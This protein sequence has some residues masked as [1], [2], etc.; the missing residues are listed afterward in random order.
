MPGELIYDGDC[1]F[2][3]RSVAHWRAITDGKI[4]AVPYQEAAERFPGLS[5]DDFRQAVHFVEDGQVWKGAAA[6]FAS[7][8][9]V[10]G[11]GWL[12]SAYQRSPLFAR[13]SEWLYQELSG[14]R[15]TA[16]WVTQLLWRG[17]LWQELP[18][19]FPNS[20]RTSVWLFTRILAVIY[21]IAFLS[22]G[23]QVKGLIGQQGILP[24]APY[25]DA[26]RNA[27]G[28]FGPAFWNVPSIFWWNSTDPMLQ[29]VCWLGVLLAI[30][31]ALGIFQRPI[32]VA[33]F[34][35]Y[36]S[37]VTA[38]QV[39][40]GYQWD[41]LLLECG[42]LAIFLTPSRP[43]VWLFQW[44][45]F[46]L[47]FESGCVKLL[48][49]DP[50][51][52]NLTALA[53][54]YQTQPLPTPLAW[55]AFQAP[56]WFHKISTAGVFLIELGAPFLIF[57]SRR[58]KHLA[59]GAFGMLQLLILLTGNYTFF[60][61]L[62]LGLCVLLLDDPSWG[63]W[64]PALRSAGRRSS[65]VVSLLLLGF[66]LALS[67]QGFSQVFSRSLPGAKLLQGFASRLAPFGVVNTYGLFASMTTMRMEIEV[68]GSM[69]GETWRT[70][71][72]R[73]KPGDIHR[74]PPWIAPF[75]PRLDWQMW[76]AALGNYQEN[77]WF[78]R[79]V[80][81][82]LTPSPAVLRLMQFD[83]F[84]GHPPRYIR[85]LAY[86]Y[87]FTNFAEQRAGGAWWHR[88]LKGVYFP[89]VSLHSQNS[90]AGPAHYFL[91]AEQRSALE[92]PINNHH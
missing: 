42:F 92:P 20:Y 48:S 31:C 36:L 52:A 15:A 68:Q 65:S 84:S 55:Y 17:T 57:G 27:A 1:P 3:R 88:D 83:P 47:M 72:F 66:I 56:L 25:L 79:F 2:C 35:L 29:A 85:A 21:G 33:L 49:H 34:V 75:Q 53:F 58:M 39:F 81:A 38:G 16:S 91:K 78:E 87:R 80:A 14:R 26:I 89:A 67:Y 37:V 18:A 41:Y 28:S 13:V 71:S 60:N 70:Y 63:R 10:R 23:T 73:Y 77:P 8:R 19:G 5:Q 12:W 62:T 30:I 76:F 54:H 90:D 46:R 82:L 11:Y 22:F 4:P 6:I 40:M 24:V 64:H 7:L 86:E 74:A 69:D 50:T 43:R 61:F 59:V 9:S 45:L 44:L 51:W 32:F